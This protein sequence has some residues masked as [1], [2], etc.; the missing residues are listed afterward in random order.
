MSE[1]HA[2]FRAG[3]T[4]YCVVPSSSR[5]ASPRPEDRTPRTA[6]AH[7]RQRCASSA[8]RSSSCRDRATASI[9]PGWLSCI[10]CP[11]IAVMESA[12]SS[13]IT[14][15]THAATYSPMLCPSIASGLTPTAIHDRASEYSNEKSAGWVM[16]VRL[17]CCAADAIRAASGNNTAADRHPNVHVT[18]PRIDQYSCGIRA[19]AY[20]GPLPWREYWDP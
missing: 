13:E 2:K 5:I 1:R 4:I 11:R 14:P 19:H 16:A 8:G 7:S 9:N 18:L 3:G 15:A 12:S 10:N 20:R 17:N 6:W